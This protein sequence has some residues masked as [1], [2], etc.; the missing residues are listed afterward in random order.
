MVSKNGQTIHLK[1]GDT[2][3]QNGTRH[4]LRNKGRENATMLS[5]IL[6]AKN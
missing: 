5:V 4:A 3:I 1:R 2:V 6:D